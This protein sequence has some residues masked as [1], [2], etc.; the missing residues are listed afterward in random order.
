MQPVKHVHCSLSLEFGFR[1]EAI[2]QAGSIANRIC[3]GFQF[4]LRPERFSKD[5][6]ETGF[7]PIQF[8][9]IDGVPPG[10]VSSQAVEL[11]ATAL[12]TLRPALRNYGGRVRRN[13]PATGRNATPTPRAGF[14]GLKFNLPGVVHRVSVSPPLEF[15]NQD[16]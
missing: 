12:S 3:F 9:P 1:Q 14:A 4:V 13:L 2:A 8:P 5:A 6:G 11:V 16:V 15:R 7:K 10:L